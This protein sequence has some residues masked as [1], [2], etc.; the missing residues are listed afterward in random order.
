MPLAL[1]EPAAR[2]HV[3]WEDGALGLLVPCLSGRPHY[4]QLFGWHAWEA[5]QWEATITLAHAKAGLKSGTSRAS[6]PVRSHLGQPVA[7]RARRLGGG[8]DEVA[9]V[10][11]KEPKQLAV[12]GDRLVHKHGLLEVPE[13]AQVRFFDAE[14]AGWVADRPDGTPLDYGGAEGA[15]ALGRS[16]PWPARQLA[17]SGGTTVPAPAARCRAAPGHWALTPRTRGPVCGQAGSSLSNV[18]E[19]IPQRMRARKDARAQ[20]LDVRRPIGH[21]RPRLVYGYKITV[22]KGWAEVPEVV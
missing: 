16:K 20:G 6:G 10:L 15:G 13:R 12:A 4:V 5:A 1:V 21:R 22:G 14:M 7:P 11:G 17:L 3:A 9:K 2:R 19:H 8:V 18:F